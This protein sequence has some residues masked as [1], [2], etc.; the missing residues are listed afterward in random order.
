MSTPVYLPQ[1]LGT[2]ITV[3]LWQPPPTGPVSRAWEI[4]EKIEEAVNV[5]H[6]FETINGMPTA[7]A[8]GKFRCRS[9]DNEKKLAVLRIHKQIY[10]AGSE[11]DDPE[12]R[13]PQAVEPYKSQELIALKALQQRDCPAVPD[14]LGY[15]LAKQSMLANVPRG[16]PVYLVWKKVP[17]ESLTHQAWE[18]PLSKRA[19]IR[20]KFRQTYVQFVE[21]RPM[22][23][24]ERLST[25]G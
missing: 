12:N 9:S 18:A 25:T 15:Q 10:F 2:K 4:T 24:L 22:A 3:D 5:T 1:L 17:G 7:Y 11:G 6:E 16:C 13:K 23:D 19:E 21:Y 14:S 20:S 8:R